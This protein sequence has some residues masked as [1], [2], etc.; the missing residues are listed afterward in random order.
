M[1]PRFAGM[2][3]GAVLAAA[4]GCWLR[5]GHPWPASLLAAWTARLPAAQ[6]GLLREEDVYGPL[7]PEDAEDEAALLARVPRAPQGLVRLLVQV[8]S[9]K[10]SSLLRLE[11]LQ[12]RRRRRRAPG[13]EQEGGG[14]SQERRNEE[15]LRSLMYDM[16]FLA[17]VVLKLLGGLLLLLVPTTLLAYGFLSLP[18]PLALH[19]EFGIGLFDAFLRPLEWLAVPPLLGAARLAGIPRGEALGEGSPEP[20]FARRAKRVLLGLVVLNVG[21]SLLAVV[22]LAQV[23]LTVR[24]SGILEE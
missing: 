23:V 21:S 22:A 2:A 7:V 17:A 11:E 18:A 4:L 13:R 9:K 12:R 16:L 5:R 20:E 8:T 14:A 24:I 6:R 3:S 1:R 15:A 10:L 19:T